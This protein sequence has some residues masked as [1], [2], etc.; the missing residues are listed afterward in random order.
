MPNWTYNTIRVDGTPRRIKA[1]L[2]SVKG[3]NGVFDFNRLIPMPEFLEHTRSGRATIDGKQ[4][5]SWYVIDPTRVDRADNE[6][7]FTPEE[8]AQL[9]DLGCESWYDWSYNN[10]GTKWNA[11]RPEIT[12]DRVR[13]G[14]L[15]IR[16]DT[17]WDKPPPIIDKLFE[18]FPKLSIRWTWQYEGEAERHSIERE[19]LVDDP[20][21]M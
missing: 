9:R 21:E 15:E 11:C 16:F 12:E 1:F 13:D 10:W 20:S 14:Y 7:C 19:V 6:R 18:K 17:A 2:K 4:V 8:E 3:E 5:S